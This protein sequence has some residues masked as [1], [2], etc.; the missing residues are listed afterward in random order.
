MNYMARKLSTKRYNRDWIRSIIK[1]ASSRHKR[2]AKSN[3]KMQTKLFRLNLRDLLKGAVTA[4]L[5]SVVA[6]LADWV[7]VPGFDILTADW[8]LLFT[9]GAV[10]GLGYIVKNL[11]T[12]EKG[13]ILGKV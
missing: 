3:K 6:K 10:A 12:D 5:T 4:V 9:V 7:N 11:L 8:S 1:I 13:K 2:S